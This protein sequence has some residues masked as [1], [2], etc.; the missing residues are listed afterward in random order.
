MKVSPVPVIHNSMHSHKMN[1]GCPCKN[2]TNPECK[3]TGSSCVGC[4][5]EC[6]NES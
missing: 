5:C 3:C 2:C 6:H 4:E 1:S